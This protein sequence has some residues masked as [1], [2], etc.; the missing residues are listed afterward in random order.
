MHEGSS[1]HIKSSKPCKILKDIHLDMMRSIICEVVQA[2]V[3]PIVHEEMQACVRPII[4]E[5]VNGIVRE[6]V[7]SLF[8]RILTV[9]FESLSHPTRDVHGLGWVG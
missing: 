8:E 2:C 5:K 3:R 1:K 6:Q 9:I 7:E 4:Q